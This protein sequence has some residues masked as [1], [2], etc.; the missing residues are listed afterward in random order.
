[1]VS[2]DLEIEKIFNSMKNNQFDNYS[3]LQ[4]KNKN[5]LENINKN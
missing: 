2:H 1:M 4:V 5:M 3:D